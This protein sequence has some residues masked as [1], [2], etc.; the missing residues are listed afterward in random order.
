MIDDYNIHIIVE[1]ENFK[2]IQNILF[3]QGYMWNSGKNYIETYYETVVLSLS[4]KMT[5]SYSPYES[6]HKKWNIDAMT[7]KDY[8]NKIRINKLER[9]LN[10]D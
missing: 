5:L 10:D 3:K 8:L 6:F 2:D 9:I 7:Y 1:Q 4:D